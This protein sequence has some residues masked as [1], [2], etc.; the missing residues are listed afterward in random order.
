MTL[1]DLIAKDA[2]KEAVASYCHHIDAR[3]IDDWCATFTADGVWDGGHL[4]KFSG[5]AELREFVQ[6]LPKI[7]GEGALRH[8][9]SNFLITVDGDKAHLIAYLDL[10]Q[11]GEGGSVALI[12]AATYDIDYVRQGGRW[13]I[14]YMRIIHH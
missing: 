3:R 8:S 14:K 7:L 10:M 1:E 4:G 5:Q 9:V 11:V 6:S 12:D 2:L 13:L